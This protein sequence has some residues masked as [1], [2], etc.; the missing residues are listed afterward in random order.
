MRTSEWQCWHNV[1]GCGR[2]LTRLPG[3][4]ASLQ[5]CYAALLQPHTF[6]RVPGEAINRTLRQFSGLDTPAQ[7]LAALIAWYALSVRALVVPRLSA[8][9]AQLKC[10][11]F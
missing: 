3:A 8:R 7:H 2:G 4:F 1:S 5:G 6:G 11:F 9:P 10:V